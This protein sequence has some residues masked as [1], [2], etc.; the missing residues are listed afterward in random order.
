MI[1]KITL[2]DRQ[3][4]GLLI[5]IF[6]FRVLRHFQHL[7]VMSSH[8]SVDEVNVSIEREPMVVGILCLLE[9]N[10][11]EST[12][13][14]AKWREELRQLGRVAFRRFSHSRRLLNSVFNVQ[15]LI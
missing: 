15:C 3:I 11:A 14:Q 1:P 6:A 9:K 4:Y 13:F 7:A 10:T 2:Q 8:S 12:T 5:I